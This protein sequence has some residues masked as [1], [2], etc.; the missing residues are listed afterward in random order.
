[1]TWVTRLASSTPCASARLR[2][3]VDTPSSRPRSGMRASTGR[4]RGCGEATPGS[5]VSGLAAMGQPRMLTTSLTPSSSGHNSGSRASSIARRLL[6]L[7]CSA[8]PGTSRPRKLA[9]VVLTSRFARAGSPA[10][11][12]IRSSHEKRCSPYLVAR[13]AR[14]D[15]ATSPTW[16]GR[17]RGPRTTCSLTTSSA[18]APLRAPSTLRAT[19]SVAVTSSAARRCPGSRTT[20]ATDDVNEPPVSIRPRSP[21]RWWLM[22]ASARRAVAR[23]APSC[24]PTSPPAPLASRT[25]RGCPGNA[26]SEATAARA[27]S[28]V[29]GVGRWSRVQTNGPRLLMGLSVA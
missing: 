10:V 27:A 23:S 22:A 21:G 1:M 9:A 28:T 4:S 3:S 25:S 15:A 26:A 7:T 12:P 24:Q 2:S 6:R 14:S 18:R 13:R 16:R 11:A 17:C 19:D 5:T 20:A 29:M 8:S